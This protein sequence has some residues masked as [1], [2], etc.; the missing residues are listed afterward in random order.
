M[1]PYA[2]T[3]LAARQAAVEH[4]ARATIGKVIAEPGAANAVCSAVRAWLDVRAPD[5]RTLEDTVDQILAVAGQESDANRVDM[6]ARQESFSPE[7]EFDAAAGG[8][9][10][11]GA[12]RPGDR[13]AR[14]AYRGRA[15]RRGAGRP[16][17]H[18]DAVR[19]QPHRGVPLAGRARRG[20]G[21]RGRGHRAG[22][23]A[24]G[25]GRLMTGPGRQPARRGG[26]SG[27]PARGRGRARRSGRARIRRW[28]AELA[29]LGRGGVRSGVLIEAAA[30]MFRGGDP[31]RAGGC[32]AA[33]HRAAAGPHPARPGQRALARLPP[34]AAR[35]HARR[36][37]ARSGPGG[38]GC[39]R[40]PGGWRRT[41]TWRWPGPSTPRWP[42][43]G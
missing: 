10:G 14:P 31:G 30:G 29:W 6:A 41:A 33:G 42:W 20:R 21:L 27:R 40:S 8:P 4:G 3:V 23:R 15:R 36:A 35:D 22:G 11:G 18:R 28:H 26:R 13:G 19:P 37:R 43:P 12:G 9:A 17:A 38:S 16:A 5:G 25:P 24:A 2:A 39:T 1:I 34:R 7:V 32:G